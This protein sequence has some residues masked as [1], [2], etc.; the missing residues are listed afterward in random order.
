M[1]LIHTV[2]PKLFC[3][4]VHKHYMKNYKTI[5]ARTEGKQNAY[6]YFFAAKSFLHKIMYS[7]VVIS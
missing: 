3:Y 4:S 7:N 2:H 1:Y 6:L 5:T